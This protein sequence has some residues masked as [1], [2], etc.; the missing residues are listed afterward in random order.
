M[1]PAL[2]DLEAYVEGLLFPASSKKV[3]PALVL[4]DLEAYME[5]L[6]FP[7]SGHKQLRN[8]KYHKLIPTMTIYTSKHT[9]KHVTKPMMH[10]NAANSVIRQSRPTNWKSTRQVKKC[11][12]V[13]GK[14]RS[15]V[16]NQKKLG[17]FKCARGGIDDLLAKSDQRVKLRLE[18]DRGAMPQT[19]N[20]MII[21]DGAKKCVDSSISSS[22]DN[23]DDEMSYYS[24]SYFTTDVSYFRSYDKFDE[25]LL[26]RIAGVPDKQRKWR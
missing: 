10:S 1:P 2:E 13:L 25:W 22:Y 23:S 4:E 3:P 7:V 6:L 5:G 9:P 8:E 24:G 18:S 15:N 12:K 11:V 14:N 17:V 21:K 16:D 19:Y 20:E 26:D